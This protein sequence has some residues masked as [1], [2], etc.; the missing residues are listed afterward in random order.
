MTMPALR[1]VILNDFSKSMPSTFDRSSVVV[2]TAGGVT[3]L[4]SALF[5]HFR[6]INTTVMMFAPT[7][8]SFLFSAS[9]VSCNVHLVKPRNDGMITPELIESSVDDY[10]DIRYILLP[11]PNNPTGQYFTKDEL[12][13]IA[14]LAFERNLVILSDEIFHKLIHDRE[15][16]FISIASIEVDGKLMLERTVV[17][18]S[19]SKDHGLAAL[20]SG[21]AIGP[22]ELMGRLCANWFTFAT[23]FNVDDL[24]QIVTIAALS[25][26]SEEYYQEQQNFLRDNRDLVIALAEEINQTVGYDALKITRPSAG[27]FLLIDASGL[28]DRVYHDKVLDSDITLYE[29]LLQ[30]TEGAVAFLPASCGG[31]NAIDMKLRLTLSSSEADIRLGMKRFGNFVQKLSH[32]NSY[33]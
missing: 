17:L 12:E 4:A 22:K 14:R 25:H 9:S 29:L 19:V 24:A 31:Y 32:R 7:Y 15:Q 28:R 13:K 6:K 20:R 18:R 2:H 30:A 11:N 21:Y 8:T 27:I 26:T 5:N 1:D 23:T 16:P 3:H 33:D 10:P